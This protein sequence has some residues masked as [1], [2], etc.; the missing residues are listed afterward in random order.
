MN[1]PVDFTDARRIVRE[2]LL[3]RWTSRN[4]TLRIAEHGFKDATHWRVL[5][6][7]APTAGDDPMPEDPMPP[8]ETAYLVDRSTGG[9]EIVPVAGNEARLAEMLPWGIGSAT[10]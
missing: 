3:D 5:A 4:G 9:L 2:H 6:G 10:S 8:D 1:S 7:T